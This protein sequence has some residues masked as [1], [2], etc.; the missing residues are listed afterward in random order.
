ML[1]HADVPLAQ[2]AAQGKDFNWI[3]PNCGC[4]HEKVW[5][6]GYVTRFFDGIDKPVWLKRYRC[7]GC[8]RVITMI[9]AG[10]GRRYRTQ[11]DDIWMAI[12]ARLTTR[13][14]PR[15]LPRQRGGHWL[16]RFLSI[17]KMDFPEED[18]LEVLD[19]LRGNG[20]HFFG[21]G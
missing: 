14:W 17:C 15:G 19:R 9:P 5:G 16:C 10:F 3:R 1:E 4:G 21:R 11:I 20:V 18:P 2:V 12:K 13:L 7:P 8:A 6:H